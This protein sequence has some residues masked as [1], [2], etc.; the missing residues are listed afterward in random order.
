[1]TLRAV[2]VAVA[3]WRAA[4][5]SSDS[6]RR[7]LG[8]ALPIRRVRSPPRAA[9]R[10]AGTAGGDGGREVG[11]DDG[12]GDAAGPGGRVRGDGRAIPRVL[13]LERLA[14]RRGGRGRADR[15]GAGE[16]ARA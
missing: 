6:W 14:A 4:C 10:F 11:A 9:A 13:R 8:G 15:R 2:V 1:M 7:R 3:N 16:R 5:H 12:R